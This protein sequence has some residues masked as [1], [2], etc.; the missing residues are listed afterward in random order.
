MQIFIK[1]IYI[2]HKIDV[3]IM[4]SFLWAELG[5]LDDMNVSH[6]G[7]YT[8]YIP[9]IFHIGL[10]KAEERVKKMTEQGYLAGRC[11][12]LCAIL[13]FYQENGRICLRFYYDL[14]YFPRSSG[15][16]YERLRMK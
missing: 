2:L 15:W 7:H 5:E 9:C 11:Y 14:V 4:L 8:Q 13:T 3:E 12:V 16:E 1:E 6:I 10:R